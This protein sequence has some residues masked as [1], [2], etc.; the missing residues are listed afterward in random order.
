MPH[1]DTICTCIPLYGASLISRW[2]QRA[3]AYPGALAEKHLH[4]QLAAVDV[5]HLAL[6]TARENP[7]LVY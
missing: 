6:H 4:E 1:F 2:K 3:Q 7:T 5:T